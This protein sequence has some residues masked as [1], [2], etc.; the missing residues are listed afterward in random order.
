MSNGLIPDSVHSLADYIEQKLVKYADK[1]AYSALGL[2]LSFKEVDEKSKALACW[3]QQKSG[4]KPGDRIAIQLPNINQNPIAVYA[5]LRAG[6]VVVNTNPLYTTREMQHQFKDSG[7]K[8]IIILADFLPKLEEIK[9]QTD[10]TC[11]ITTAAAEL[12]SGEVQPGSGGTTS[13]SEAIREGEALELQ[14]RP[15]ISLDDVC[16]L[17]YTGGTTGVSKGA[18]LSH[19]N[20]LSNSIQTLD[21]LGESFV[22][23]E[24]VVICP[25]PLYHIYAFTVCMMTFFAKGSLTVLIPNPRDPDAF[26]AAMAP[27]KLTTFA[28]IN[29]LFIGLSGHPG[30]KQLDFSTLKLTL[31]GGTALTQ[32]AVDVWKQT[33]GCSITEGYGL[34]ETAPVLTFNMPGNEHLG[35]VGLPLLETD[36]QLLDE[37]DKPVE[38]GKD[39]QIAAKGPQ[40][41]LGYWNRPDE[42]AKVMTTD[43]YFKT[44]DVGVRM[45]DGCIK[46]VD[47]LKDLVIVSG[48]NVYPNEV[49]N[50]LTGHSDIL[51]AAVIGA[52]DDK[53]GE[54]V[55]AYITV[56]QPVEQSSIIEFCKE[57]L[58][59]YKVPKEIHVLEELP[60]S[61][62]GKILRRELRK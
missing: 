45:P 16:M 57:K 50:V 60:K 12:L 48:F 5:A 31:S 61:T 62:V 8:A 53:T 23:G 47:R 29:T 7:A 3:L 40:V 1:S 37:N 33:T 30:F 22:E 56:S 2:T 35:T 9:G 21:R 19:R 24:E 11:V 54:R 34:S 43:G 41:M 17:Q 6:L 14:S 36:I 20:V 49:E 52:P 51:E 26:V 42:T 27:F 18:A 13:L 10:I 39:G 55:C 58:T 32:S 28:G 38:D 15:A 25:L 4:L 46:I 44:G 59:N